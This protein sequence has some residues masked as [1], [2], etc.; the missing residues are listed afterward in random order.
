M[1]AKTDSNTV[2]VRV[3]VTW[4]DEKESTYSSALFLND[5]GLF[6][7][8]HQ[9]GSLRMKFVTKERTPAA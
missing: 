5:E 4:S 3:T 2:H 8:D 6:G 1:T 7:A 9:T